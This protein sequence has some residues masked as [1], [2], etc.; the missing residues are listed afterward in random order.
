[1][2]TAPQLEPYLHM[3]FD[4]D[5]LHMGV[6]LNNREAVIAFPGALVGNPHFIIDMGASKVTLRALT[7]V[8]GHEFEIRG[9]VGEGGP[10]LQIV[11]GSL[12]LHPGMRRAN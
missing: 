12:S 8:R 1:M 3:D 11:R 5:R 7:T 6:C 10:D 9:V 4:R 2:E